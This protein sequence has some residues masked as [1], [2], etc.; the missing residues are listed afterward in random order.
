MVL[1]LCENMEACIVRIILRE[2]SEPSSFIN[3]E[4]NECTEEL[5]KRRRQLQMT[6]LGYILYRWLNKSP[7]HYYYPA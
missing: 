4:E 2:L 1:P 7:L 6:C 5:A 3:Q